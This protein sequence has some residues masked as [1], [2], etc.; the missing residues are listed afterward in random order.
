MNPAIQIRISVGF[1][2]FTYALAAVTA[3]AAISPGS[4]SLPFVFVENRGQANT[5]IRYVGTGPEFKA[6][7]EDHGVTLQQGQTAVRISFE[8]SAKPR[9][10]AEDPIGA[11]ANYLHGNDPSHWQTDLPLFTAIRYAGLWPGIELSYRAERSRVKAEYVVAAGADPSRV[12]LKFEGE[13]Q[14][15]GDGRL[16]VSGASGDFVEDRPVLYQSP[17]GK[18]VEIAGGFER[19]PGGLIGFWTGAYDR[20]QPLVID[21]AI[22]FSGYFGGST[23]DDITAI[24][25]DGLNNV[26]VAGWT[27]STDLPATAGARKQT[28]GGVDAFVASFLPNG[29]AL[30]YCTYLGG[31]GDDRAFGLAIDSGRNVY[32]TGWTSSQNFPVLGAFQSHLRGTRDAF[33]AKLNAA[34][35]A[36]VYSTYLG[37]SAVDAGY[38][39]GLD[40]IDSA[41]IVG[42]STSSDLPVTAGV[43]QSKPGGSQDVFVAKLS[44]AGNAL[45]FLTYLGGSGIDHGACLAIGPG[46]AYYV[47]GYTWSSNFPTASERINRSPAA[48]RMVSSP[49]C[50]PTGAS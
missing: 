50:T 36:L 2:F 14:I 34:G 47:G 20:S 28:G 27:A 9:V 38:A 31:S 35:N 5:G 29:G 15:Q 8:G 4:P 16:R 33:V 42:D 1:L 13:P 19:L 17:G 18:R 30:I 43:F 48:G 49:S 25:I 11:R 41:V 6:W 45:A 40:A 10:T 21:P 22:L 44:P 39:I 46:G 26:V 37:G 32:V 7:F 3:R 23:E 24:G 12:L